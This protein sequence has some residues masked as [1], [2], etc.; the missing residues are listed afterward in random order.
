MTGEELRSAVRTVWEEVI[1]AGVDDDTD[2]FDAGGTSFAALRIV[3]T[4]NSRHAIAVPVKVLFEASRF[5][6]FTAALDHEP[7]LA[8]QT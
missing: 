6:D 8:R 4:L 5:A 3:A 1:G 7:G 2:F